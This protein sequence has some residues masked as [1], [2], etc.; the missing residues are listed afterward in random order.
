MAYDYHVL[1]GFAAVVI[2]GAGYIPYYRDIFRGTTKPHPFT[3]L[4]FSIP[5][6]IAFA[7]QIVSGGG[8]GAWVSAITCVATFGIAAIAFKR[9][10]KDITVFDWACFGGSL[11][12]ILLWK[13]TSDPLSAVVI[14]TIADLFAFAPTFR[15]GFLRPQ[16]ETAT[17]FAI[18]TFKYMLSLFALVTFN[19]TTALFPVAMAAAN[20]AIVLMLLA[21]R[22]A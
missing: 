12:G 13:L 11:L 14:V 1:L 22:Q 7:A 9:G 18:S 3:W 15:K 21:R 20:A 4:G 5:N 2:G 19:L 8:P 6:G 10:E 17:L 16:E